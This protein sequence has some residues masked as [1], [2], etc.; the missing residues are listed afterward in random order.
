MV[1]V[2][3]I[4]LPIFTPSMVSSSRYSAR[5]FS[6]IEVMVALLVL[7]IGVLGML[8]LQMTSLRTSR[9]TL[10]Q[11]SALQL[12]TDIAE[13]LKGSA[14]SP[15]MLQL[16]LQLDYVATAS[17]MTG[18]S[19]CYGVDSAC[20]ATE[21]AA[22]AIREWQQRLRQMLPGSR[23]KI[24]RD[25]SPWQTSRKSMRWECDDAGATPPA[26]SAMS[27]I[28][29]KIGWP[30]AISSPSSAAFRAL[31]TGPQLVLPVAAF[32]L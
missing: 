12:A 32:A 31:N 11:S 7:A 8:M 24:C 23:L 13:Q 21:I 6:L 1:A 30:V 2:S 3:I 16:F 17:T 15:E 4:S 26:N 20:S 14:R 29:I 5:G 22:S 27:P 9:E 19:D 28:W 10:M 25:A 18:G